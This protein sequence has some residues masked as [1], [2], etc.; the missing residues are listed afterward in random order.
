MIPQ[1]CSRFT[2]ILAFLHIQGHLLEGSSRC[3]PFDNFKSTYLLFTHFYKVNSSLCQAYAL[4][5]LGCQPTLGCWV[6]HD[7][8]P[9]I[10]LVMSTLLYSSL[11][12]WVCPA[13]C[14]L[15]RHQRRASHPQN[16]YP[17]GNHDKKFTKPLLTIFII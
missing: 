1:H 10:Q 9:S 15:Q 4:C 5:T 17:G 14:S 16:P 13:F 11:L 7:S 3:I 8:R 2:T 6:T 12:P